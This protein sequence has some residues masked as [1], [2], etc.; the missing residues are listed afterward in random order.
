MTVGGVLKDRKG[1]NLPGVQVSSPALTDKDR[2]DAQ[3][4]LDLGVDYLALSFVRRPE[5]VA[6]LQTLIRDAGH[7]TP[8]IAK[9]EKPEALDAI[10]EILERRRWADGG[11]RRPGRGTGAGGGADRAA[12][13]GPAGPARSTSRS[14]WPRRCWSR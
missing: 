12:R 13:P 9:I 1:M 3:F 5:D 2:E 10:D 7:D 6:D 8:I 14:S 11:A 4:A